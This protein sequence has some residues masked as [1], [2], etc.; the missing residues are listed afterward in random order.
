MSCAL[1]GDSTQL[2]TPKSRQYCETGQSEGVSSAP[3]RTGA[4][5]PHLEIQLRD[6]RRDE[7]QW[8]VPQVFDVPQPR[9]DLQGVDQHRI[10]VA[11]LRLIQ[12]SRLIEV[13]HNGDLE[14][15]LL[16]R[17]DDAWIVM[18]RVDEEDAAA[19]MG[20]EGLLAHSFQLPFADLAVGARTTVSHMSRERAQAENGPLDSK[21]ELRPPSELRRDPELASHEL[22]QTLRD[23][24]SETRTTV[25]LRSHEASAWR[26]SASPAQGR[27]HSP[28]SS[29]HRPVQTY[30]R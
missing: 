20:D 3:K 27:P 17:L 29:N 11:R 22:D 26:S 13:V 1:V 21:V 7:H 28:S 23:R 24:E 6:L 12:Q 4:C 9:N 19:W 14:P 30:R 15:E 5:K 16:D 25:F 8:D 18:Q 2:A 10:K